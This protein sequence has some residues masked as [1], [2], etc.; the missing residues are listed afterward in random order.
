MVTSA[1]PATSVGAG[2]AIKPGMGRSLTTRN[3]A[4]A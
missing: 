2:A 4:T 1:F 3:P